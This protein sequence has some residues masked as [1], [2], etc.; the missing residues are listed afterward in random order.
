MEANWVGEVFGQRESELLVGSVKG[1]IGCVSKLIVFFRNY[2]SHSIHI[3]VP[4]RHLE[5]CAFLASL[6][7]V[8]AMFQTRLLPPTVNLSKPN[9]A[10]AWD[11]WNMRAPTEVL[12][13]TG[14]KKQLLVSI[15]SSGIGG[16]NGHALVESFSPAQPFQTSQPPYEHP[17]LIVAGGLSPRSAS[18]IGNSIDAAWRDSALEELP[19]LSSIWSRRGRQMLWQTFSIKSNYADVVPF[20]KP[21]LLPKSI[22]GLV[23]VF[24]GQGPQYIHSKFSYTICTRVRVFI[25]VRISGKSAF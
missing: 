23:F 2:D 5:I 12:S 4:S 3:L 17:L 8:C 20:A 10:I 15:A 19:V 13:I 24:S 14:S 11:R 21:T 6:C 1:N 9:P 18:E 22:P 16:A 25:W 7:K